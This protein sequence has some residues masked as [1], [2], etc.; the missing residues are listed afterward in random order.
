MRRVDDVG[1]LN[2]AWIFFFLARRRFTGENQTSFSDSS[3]TL[4]SVSAA[5]YRVPPYTSS[6]SFV[7]PRRPIWQFITVTSATATAAEETFCLAAG[8]G[9]SHRIIEAWLQPHRGRRF[10][11]V[12]L[13]IR[14]SRRCRFLLEIPGWCSWD[15]RGQR[16][17]PQRLIR[18][19][20]TQQ[21]SSIATTWLLASFTKLSHWE[22]IGSSR[23]KDRKVRKKKAKTT[24]YYAFWNYMRNCR[25]LA[26]KANS[27]QL[28][29]SNVNVKN[30]KWLAKNDLLLVPKARIN[31]CLLASS[32]M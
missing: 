15:G 8:G 27:W 4:I 17:K 18:A 20:V 2:R 30:T 29:R 7:T 16:L 9:G 32:S 11:N 12:S 25:S 10:I 31:F 14:I 21:G 19:A 13:P 3:L 24:V 1:G 6:P 23:R 22:L 26:I 5:H 28:V